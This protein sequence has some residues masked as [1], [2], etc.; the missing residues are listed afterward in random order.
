MKRGQT[1]TV[2]AVAV[3]QFAQVF[4]EITWRKEALVGF[5]LSLVKTF[6]KS[7]NC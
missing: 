5:Y 3:I 6:E 1:K 2:P 4:L 7:K